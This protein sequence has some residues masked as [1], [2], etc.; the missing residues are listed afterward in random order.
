MSAMVRRSA[1]LALLAACVAGGAVAARAA[2]FEYALDLPAHQ[3]LSYRLEFEVAHPGPVRLDA[4]WSTTRVLVFRV[5]RPDE[6]PF[7]RSGPSPQRL[8]LEAGP[9]HLDPGTPWTLVISGLPSRQP[10]EGRLVV[11]LPDAP[12]RG[13]RE[14][15]ARPV[16]PAR[17]EDPWRRR[18]EIPVGLTRE[19][20][21]LYETTERFRGLVV[22]ATEP[23][24]YRWQ[25]DMLR[26]L[27]DRR[28]RAR[29]AASLGKPS[30][31][32]MFERIVEAVVSLDRLRVA[33]SKPLTG[34]VPTDGV[35][36]RVWLSVRD[37]RFTPV[38]EELGAL[39]DELHRGHAP[40]LEDEVWFSSF[41]SCLIVC[42]QHFE[43]RARLGEDRASNGELV[44]RQWGQV[45][46]AV[47]ALD[48][49]AE[50]L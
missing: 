50:L 49:L 11:T 34:P 14:A 39:L 29:S 42:G 26:F 30:T 15:E 38:E 16:P 37:P 17:E 46:A 13:P 12:Q 19:Q 24:A 3:T 18:V 43:E 44:R 5:E 10:A 4:E 2:S 48:A 9:E 23:D 33:E 31:R 8:E 28:D 40:E 47:D 7:R 21:R 36:R 32:T 22:D 25:D 41:L 6:A 1:R 20:Y 35:H 45:L 27:A